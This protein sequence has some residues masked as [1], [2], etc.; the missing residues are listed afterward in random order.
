MTTQQIY[1]KCALMSWSHVLSSLQLAFKHHHSEIVPVCHPRP[2]TNDTIHLYNCTLLIFWIPKS[3]HHYPDMFFVPPSSLCS[4]QSSC[5]ECPS[6]YIYWLQPY[7]SFK[8][9]SPKYLFQE[10]F[11]DLFS[12]TLDDSCPTWHC[13]KVMCRQL[14]PSLQGNRV[15]SCLNTF[16]WT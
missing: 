15:S 12:C 4:W 3:T 2:S 9:H 13:M 11:S 5:L 7:L 6:L 1:I 10:A 16:V 8:A 14:L